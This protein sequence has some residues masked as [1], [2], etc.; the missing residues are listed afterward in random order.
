[1]LKALHHGYLAEDYTFGH[2]FA[3]QISFLSELKVQA[4]PCCIEKGK[5]EEL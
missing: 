5:I 1:L 4:F 2:P 3:S